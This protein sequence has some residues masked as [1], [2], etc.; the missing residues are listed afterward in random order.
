MAKYTSNQW[1]DCMNK[2]IELPPLSDCYGQYYVG[3]NTNTHMRQVEGECAL[4]EDLSDWSWFE[5]HEIRDADGNWNFVFDD[6]GRLFVIKLN[7][8]VENIYPC[9]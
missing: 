6:A 1:Y 3:E 4:P 5:Y 8:G 2:P 9:Q 7:Y